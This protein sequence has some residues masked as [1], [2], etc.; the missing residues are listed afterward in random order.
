MS[1]GEHNVLEYDP[2]V[3][4]FQ[5]ERILGIRLLKETDDKEQYLLKFKNRSYIHAKWATE[6]EVERYP[7][8]VAILEGFRSRFSI[9]DF[10][11]KTEHFF[12]PSFCQVDRILDRGQFRNK[13]EKKGMYWVKWKMLGYDECTWEFE[14]DIPRDDHTKIEEFQSRRRVPSVTDRRIPDR[15]SASEFIPLETGPVVKQGHQLRDYQL[16]G[17]NWLLFCWFNKRGSILADD[18]GMGKTVQ[19]VNLLEWIR[20]AQHNRGPF[21]VIAPL[22]TINQWKNK[23]EN[24]TEM[25][26]VVFQ[27]N[28]ES[29]DLITRYEFYYYDESGRVIPNLY[30]FNVLITTYETIIAEAPLLSNINWQ[31]MVVDEGH[32]LKNRQSKLMETLTFFKTE[33]RLLLTATPLQNNLEELWTLLNFIDAN[34]FGDWESFE[35]QCGNMQEGIG[36]LYKLIGPY[37]LRRL[38]TDVSMEE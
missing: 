33:H 27:G 2:A 26:T 18:I 11:G 25:N 4:E 6:D 15:P 30:K 36:N 8:G 34:T 22:S 32:R 10:E 19:A 3:E 13:E 35:E 38:R 29:R 14:D 21:L 7:N 23:F 28:R 37:I 1:S 16:Q 24:W 17:L 20:T 12:D 9:E 5:I 31:C